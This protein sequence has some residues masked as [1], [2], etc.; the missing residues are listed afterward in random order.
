MI[1]SPSAD[2]LEGKAV[3]TNQLRRGWFI[4][5]LAL[6]GLL[7]SGSDSRAYLEP[8]GWTASDVLYVSDPTSDQINSGGTATD[9][10]GMYYRWAGGVSYFRMDLAAAPVFGNNAP[11][12]AIYLDEGPGGATYG[13]GSTD[14]S[15]SYYVA[16]GIPV[17]IDAMI[18]ARWNLQ[19]SPG[20]FDSYERV[21]TNLPASQNFTQVTQIP[22]ADQVGPAFRTDNGG[23]TLEWQLPTSYLGTTMFTIYGGTMDNVQGRTYDVSEPLYALNNSN[24]P[25]PGTLALM[26][27]IGSVCLSFLRKARR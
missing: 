22:F 10:T 11:N 16:A 9:I 19:A 1:W 18:D 2:T 12:Y 25:E 20:N 17:G 21:Y 23:T 26:G 4:V 27:V 24:V 3:K 8:S 5:V 13:D 14:P 6:T 15:L 7:G